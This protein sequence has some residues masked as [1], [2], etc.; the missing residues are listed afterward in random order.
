VLDAGN[1]STYLWTTGETGRQIEVTAPG[2]YGVTVSDENG[3]VGFGNV[4]IEQVEELIP[5]IEGPT[6]ICPGEIATLS[7]PGYALYAW[8]TG[9]TTG[10]LAVSAPGVYS[11]TVTDENGCSG[12]GTVQVDQ[13]DAPEIDAGGDVV[14]NSEKAV[15]LNATGGLAYT[16]S[17]PAALISCFNCSETVV[18][19]A[20]TTI[21]Y[22]T[23]TDENGCTGTDSVTVFVV[24][25]LE[26][27][28]VNTITPNGDGKND[29]FYVRGLEPFD[30]AKLTV[31][32]RWGDVVYSSAS[33]QNDW[34]GTYNG[35]PIPAGAYL[36][37][38]RVQV[39]DQVY[40]LKGTINVIR[41]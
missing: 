27:D 28:P 40:E 19:P 14:I 41:E 1:F 29:V 5:E 25:D 2:V 26:L 24:I 23:G 15:T 34:E 36:Y 18:T 33:Y 30:N 6:L 20:E 38:L 39:F 11:V 21:F 9:A 10:E 35:K 22:V 32:N 3:C 17:G 12:E 13:F 4:S 8:S 16:W 37:L 7:S 31:F